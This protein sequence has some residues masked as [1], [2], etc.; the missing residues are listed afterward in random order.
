[1]L[2]KAREQLRQIHILNITQTLFF[3]QL[4]SAINGELQR[5][6]V[7]TVYSAIDD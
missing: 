3:I 4:L 2:R 1:L 5:G 6:F 7:Q